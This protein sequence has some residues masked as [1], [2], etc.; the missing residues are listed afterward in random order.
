VDRQITDTQLWSLFDIP[1]IEEGGVRAYLDAILLKTSI[2]FGSNL[3]SVFVDNGAGELVCMASLGADLTHKAKIQIG[4]GIA[5]MALQHGVPLIVNDPTKQTILEGQVYESR[6][7]ISSS[8]VIPLISNDR[9]LGVL[10]LARKMDEEPFNEEDLRQ[11]NTLAHQI[12]LAVAN[13]H[14][15]SEIQTAHDQIHSIFELLNVAVFVWDGNKIET[16]NP[17]ASKLLGE[18]D[19]EEVISSL[20]IPLGSTIFLARVLA[21]QGISRKFQAEHEQTTWII[22]ASPLPNG[23]VLFMIEDISSTVQTSFELARVRRLAEIGQMTAAIAHEIRNPLT[24]IRSAAQMIKIAPE[25]S[26]ELAEIVEEEAVK[27][28]E[29]CSQ[30][31]DFAKPA[32][33][34]FNPNDL[35][36]LA[37]RIAGMHAKD[38]QT[39]GVDLVLDLKSECIFDF[40][41]NQIHQVMLNLMLNALQASTEGSTV[42]VRTWEGGFEVSDDGI[43]MEKEV[44]EGLFTPFFTT[45]PKGT[46]LG[47]S[48]CRKLVEAHGGTIEVESTPGKGSSFRVRFAEDLKRVA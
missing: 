34:H 31:L 29:L 2:M 26:E 9:K 41:K 13:S 33:P 24:G 16:R 3:S 14:L 11:A 43:G 1:S 45:K 48:N 47:L 21:E 22:T 37:T 20:P 19:F 12:S 38:F 10:N 17:E 44:L 7:D 36:E 27:L 28:N 18:G 35:S 23:G 5:G 8:M 4:V 46:G 15:I 40:D 42:K 30:F 32:E 25:Q 6:R 39:A